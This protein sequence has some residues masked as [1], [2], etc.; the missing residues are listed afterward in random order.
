MAFST[1]W[2]ATWSLTHSKLGTIMAL[3]HTSSVSLV[4]VQIVDDMLPERSSCATT[5]GIRTI[6]MI[7]TLSS[8]AWRRGSSAFNSSQTLSNSRTQSILATRTKSLVRQMKIPRRWTIRQSLDEVHKT[9]LQGPALSA[10]QF[11]PTCRTPSCL[12]QRHSLLHE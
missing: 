2:F 6:R 5:S 12:P 8:A 9:Q 10:P 1:A 3:V 4:A 11:C 7:C